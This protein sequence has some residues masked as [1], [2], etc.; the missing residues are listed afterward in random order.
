MLQ[1]LSLDGLGRIG[2]RRGIHRPSLDKDGYLRYDAPEGHPRYPQIRRLVHRLVMKA[3]LNRTLTADEIVHHKNENRLDNRLEN[4]ELMSRKEH[5]DHHH[6]NKICI[7]SVCHKEFVGAHGSHFC[8]TSCKYKNQYANNKEY[9]LN[10]SREQV[11][12][13]KAARNIHCAICS[14]PLPTAHGNAKYCRGCSP[15]R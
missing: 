4:L 14:I 12:R 5:R 9:Y 13:M 11:L 8:S 1:T 2:R 7:C 6:A 3:H 10:N 15:W